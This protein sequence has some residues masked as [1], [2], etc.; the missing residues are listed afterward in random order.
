M[1]IAVI[2]GSGFIGSHVVDKLLEAGHQVVVFDKMN[3]HRKDVK[4]IQINILDPLDVNLMLAGNYDAYFILAAVSNVNHVNKNPIESVAL[5][6]IGLANILEAARRYE[7]KRVIFSSTVWVYNLANVSEANNQLGEDT[8]FFVENTNH[9]YTATKVAD[10]L[11]LVA[12][13]KQYGVNYTILRYGIPYGPRGR[14]GT[15]IFNFVNR[16]LAEQPLIIQGDGSATRNFIYVEDLAQAHVHVLQEKAANQIYNVDGPRPISVKEVAEIVREFIPAT[17]I[18][19][20]LAYQAPRSGDSKNFSAS[21]E[22][23]K[24]ELGWEPETEIH[25]GIRKHI[26]WAKEN[27]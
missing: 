2:G 18:N 15:V 8:P 4:H 5:N 13:Q 23:I 27:I 6:I 7:I 19:F 11:I 17:E 3:P 1:R 20:N 21:N 9:L 22:K 10:E 25:E 14:E 24:N 12:F 26:E 16:A